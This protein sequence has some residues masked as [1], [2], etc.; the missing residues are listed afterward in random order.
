MLEKALEIAA[1]V[2]RAGVA[3]DDATYE[4]L[5]A[6]IEVAQLWDQKAVRQV[7]DS[8]NHSVADD[9]VCKHSVDTVR[10]W[11]NVGAVAN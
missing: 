7:I 4:E 8:C 9:D 6:T 11:T 1:W 5:Q 10:P 2:Q 3:F